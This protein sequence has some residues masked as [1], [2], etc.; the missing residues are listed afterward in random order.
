MKLSPVTHPHTHT[1]TH[2]RM[3]THARTH[4]HFLLNHF[5]SVMM[6]KTITIVP[7]HDSCEKDSPPLQIRLQTSSNLC[8]KAY[9]NFVII[10]TSHCIFLIFSSP[11]SILPP[12]HLPFSSSFA[13]PAIKIGSPHMSLV[14][15]KDSSFFL[16]CCLFGVQAL[17][18]TDAI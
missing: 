9:C 15:L 13:Q 3:S 1:C 11:L 17:I 10:C 8:E 6:P 14:L 2:A 18:L 7:Y 5:L 16:N 4:T 12:P